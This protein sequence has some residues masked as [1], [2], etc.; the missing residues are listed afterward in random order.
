MS[1]LH[2]QTEVFIEKEGR[3]LRWGQDAYFRTWNGL[4]QTVSVAAF[5]AVASA[6]GSYPWGFYLF[7]F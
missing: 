5:K 4:K 2:K 6:G 7:L 3:V 1:D